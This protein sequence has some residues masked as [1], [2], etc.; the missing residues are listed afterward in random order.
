M[1]SEKRRRSCLDQFDRR[2]DSKPEREDWIESFIA[3]LR[4]LLHG[5]VGKQ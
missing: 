5:I 4:A 1:D 2:P 3:R